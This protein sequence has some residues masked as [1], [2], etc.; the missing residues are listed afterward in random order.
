LPKYLKSSLAQA[1]PKKRSI[2]HLL[3]I[4]VYLK[5]TIQQAKLSK[6]AIEKLIGWILYDF[7]D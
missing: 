2:N 4:A 1:V 3:F 7:F 5:S 6:R